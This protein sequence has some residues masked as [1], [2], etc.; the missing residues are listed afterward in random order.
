LKILGAINNAPHIS[1]MPLITSIRVLR[2]TQL[3]MMPKEPRQFLGQTTHQKLR[4]PPPCSVRP[5]MQSDLEP[6]SP[7]ESVIDPNLPLMLAWI[8]ALAISLGVPPLR[9]PAKPPLPPED[10]HIERLGL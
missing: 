9:L 2:R 10:Q 7:R 3:Q 6:V 1:K 4:Q 5:F 8:V